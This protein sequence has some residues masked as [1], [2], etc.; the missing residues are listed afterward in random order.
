MCHIPN[1]ITPMRINHRLFNPLGFHLFR[2]LLDAALRLIILYG[3]SS[4]GKSYS[5][6]Q[7]ILMLT[8]YEGENT[9]VMR[10]VGASIQ[11]SIYEDFKVAARQLGVYH[12]FKFKDG[13]RQIVCLN[14]LAKI[15]FAGLDDPE[16]I[17]GI[18]NYK[19]VVL[20]ELSEY[21]L[22]DFNQISLRLRGKDGQQI[23]V[24]F[25][26]ISESH[27]IKRELIDHEEW[28]DAPCAITIG[29]E[30][31]PDELCKVKSV[32][33]NIPRPILNP[34]T[35]EMEEHA[36]DTILIQTT[37]LNNFWVV[38]SPDGTYG[39]YDEQCVANFEKLKQHNPDLYNIYALGEW[40][41]VRSGSEFF[42]SFYL[43]KHCGDVEYDPELP[44]HV[45]I[46]S[47]VLPYFS[48]TFWQLRYEQAEAGT[49]KRLIQLDEVC[50]IPPD[51]SVKGAALLTA[52]RLK[53]YGVD[54]IILHGDASTRHAN[55]IDE[56]KRS[57]HDLFI[58]HLNKEGIE[59]IDKVGVSNPSVQ[60]T[61]E[62]IN[63]IFDEFVPGLAVVIGNRCKAS[64]EDYQLVQ[65]DEN[66]GMLKARVTDKV[67]K[68]SYEKCGHLSDCFRYVC[69]DLMRDE[70]I[71]YS[72][73][74]KHNIYAKGGAIQFFNPATKV[75][76]STRVIYCMPNINGKFVMIHAGLVGDY[77]R[78]IDTAFVETDSTDGIRDRLSSIRANT[79]FIECPQSYYP[80]VR[81]LR[82]HLGLDLRAVPEAGD[83]DRRISATSDYVRSH[84]QFDPDKNSTDPEYASF[85]NS[86]LDYNKNSQSKEASAVMSGFIVFAQKLGSNPKRL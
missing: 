11:K 14:N 52:Q 60:M 72:N 71:L 40:G 6:A 85:I 18:S 8:I 45:S 81:E 31:V 49:C 4:S 13:V 34:R 32:R 78:I 48:I 80:F 12:L 24:M 70:Y 79:N 39:Y 75:E 57:V 41:I 68:Q 27:W 84:I 73:S 20:D 61:G 43:S 15:D 10:K 50:A 38:G 29:G 26:P 3:G 86:L 30:A 74:R 25:N 7:V 21:D 77:W 28:V 55:N 66:G 37:Y 16:K 35:G 82:S 54:T 76:F 36:A 44:I 63:S 62:F 64:M 56:H 59:V 5:V 83:I 19:R 67:T 22:A 53:E 51:N 33:Y 47:N 2:C 9:L 17:K 42:G 1:T 46:D 58:A 65:K 69:I 23:I